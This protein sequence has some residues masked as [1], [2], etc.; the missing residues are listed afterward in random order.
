MLSGSSPSTVFSTEQLLDRF[1]SGTAR[2]RRGLIST[3]EKRAA[4]LASLGGSLLERFDRQGP[5]VGSSPSLPS[6]LITPH[7]SVIS[8]KRTMKPPIGSP[9]PFS[10]S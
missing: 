6:A 8:C 10:G 5:M 9:V 4:D 3:V 1:A 2:Q 7:C